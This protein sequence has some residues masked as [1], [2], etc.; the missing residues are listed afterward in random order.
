[1]C[2][3]N[4]P[5]REGLQITSSPV[6]FIGLVYAADGEAAKATTIEQ[7]RRNGRK[8]PPD[9]FNF[10]RAVAGADDVDDDEHGAISPALEVQSAR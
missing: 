3:S 6:R 8:P 10:L 2:G 7:C 1:M 9:R 4:L 5:R